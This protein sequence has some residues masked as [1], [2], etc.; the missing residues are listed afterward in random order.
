LA[1]KRGH[2]SPPRTTRGGGN[3]HQH[4]PLILESRGRSR[5]TPRREHETLEASQERGERGREG[6][7]TSPPKSRDI[8]DPRESN[9]YTPMI[10]GSG[11]R[12]KY[13]PRREPETPRGYER[14]EEYEREIGPMGRG[15]SVNLPM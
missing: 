6:K 9:Q 15:K 13:T 12:P 3:R 4:N 10:Q 2:Y 14:R 8:E 11:C 5:H 7:G 1:R